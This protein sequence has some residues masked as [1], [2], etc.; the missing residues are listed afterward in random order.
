[1]TMEMPQLALGTAPL[2]TAEEDTSSFCPTNSFAG[3]L[4]E[5]AVRSVAI[6]LSSNMRHI[7]T[8][9]IYR[10]HTSVRH[11][12]L[13]KLASGELERSDVFVTSKVFH[14]NTGGQFGTEELHC[15]P[16][17]QGEMTH[18]QV[19]NKVY[20][21]FQQ[22]LIE[23][24]VGYVDL[25]L[26]HWPGR[27][28]DKDENGNRM[29]RKAAWKAL[30][31]CY[32]KGWARSIGVSN[33]S[34]HH[35]QQLEADGGCQVRP[36]VN[37]FEASVFLQQSSI[38]SYCQEHNIVSVAYSP[39]G[40]GVNRVTSNNVV[41]KIAEQH[42]KNAG[43]VALKYLLQKGYGGIVFLTSSKERMVT[44]TQLYDFTLTEDEVQALD[45]LSRP[46]GSWGL[47]SPYNIL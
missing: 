35:L 36:M 44:N 38:L 2:K 14:P 11:V 3:F 26:L 4:P 45:Q 41:L 6:A 1:M 16:I 43:Q 25:M 31:D 19:Y 39:L 23:L 33:F 34:E 8:A 37:Q 7:D 9:L 28:R 22:T 13:Q 12:L 47:D 46:D 21:Q 24:G 30:Q 5:Q 15:M 27:I 17:D 40:R 29:R 42:G 20:E 10:S 18:D 32:H